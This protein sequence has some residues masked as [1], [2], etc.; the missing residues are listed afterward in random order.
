M[1]YFSLTFSILYILR[2]NDEPEALSWLSPQLHVEP[3]KRPSAFT[4]LPLQTWIRHRD[5]ACLVLQARVDP[6]FG[7]HGQ[8][9]WN[10]LQETGALDQRGA[11]GGRGGRQADG[12]PGHGQRLW[13]QRGVVRVNRWRRGAEERRR[14]SPNRPGGDGWMIDAW[15]WERRN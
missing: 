12:G 4:S 14:E 15:W 9:D 6:V 1:M 7:F 13:E 5:T 11:R 3:S 10:R 2:G 8:G